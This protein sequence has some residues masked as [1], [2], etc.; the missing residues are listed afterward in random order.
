MVEKIQNHFPLLEALI[1]C[2]VL[3]QNM[4]YLLHRRGCLSPVCCAPLLCPCVGD[5]LSILHPEAFLVGSVGRGEVT[6]QGNW[7]ARAVR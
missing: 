4:S 5:L 6:L 3:S 7:F 2:I 1:V